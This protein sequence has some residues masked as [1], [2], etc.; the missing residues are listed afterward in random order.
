MALMFLFLFSAGFFCFWLE[1]ISSL[2][3]DP[4]RTYDYESVFSNESRF[5]AIHGKA[6]NW[7]HYEGP[8]IPMIDYVNQNPHRDLSW[9]FPNFLDINYDCL[10]DK[11][12]QIEAWLEHLMATDTGYSFVDGIL[13]QCPLPGARNLTGGPCFHGNEVE[14]TLN[15]LSIQG[16]KEK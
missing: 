2:F 6:V 10:Y 1:Y 14:S 5:T 11:E 9:N 16:G 3:C 7:H 15:S 12:D 4:E 13:T 8:D